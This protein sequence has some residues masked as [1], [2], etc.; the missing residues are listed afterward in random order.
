MN[1]NCGLIHILFKEQ[2]PPWVLFRPAHDVG[3][4][5]G[6]LPHLG[7]DSSHGDLEC[8]FLTGFD[9]ELGGEGN[10]TVLARDRTRSGG[11]D[12]QEEEH[13]TRSDYAPMKI[14]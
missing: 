9:R 7:N 13:Y 6:L 5:P 3:L 12:Q 8:L 14:A 11:G 10:Q 2:K 1:R 4:I